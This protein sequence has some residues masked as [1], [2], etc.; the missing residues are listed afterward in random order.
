MGRSVKFNFVLSADA[1]AGDQVDDMRDQ[2]EVLGHEFTVSRGEWIEPPSFNLFCEGVSDAS[3]DRV[4]ALGQAGYQL[5]VLVT[6]KPT[7]V[8]HEGLIWNYHTGS[9]AWNDRA[10]IFVATAPNFISAWCY[11]PRAA[12]KVRRFIPNAVDIDVAWGKRFLVAKPHE[13]PRYDF[14]F[15]GGLTPRRERVLNHIAKRGHSV[16]VIPHS[17]PLAVRDSRVANSKVVI[18]PKQYHWW[19]LASPIR[20]MTALCHGRPVVAEARSREAQGRWAKV[21]SFAPE[22]AFYETAAAALGHW[23]ELHRRQTAA[24]KMLPSLVAKA[25][26][27]LPVPRSAPVHRFQEPT[28]QIIIRHHDRSSP[29]PQLLASVKGHN[30]VGWLDAVYAVPQRIGSV[31]LDKVDLLRYPMI[32]RFPNYAAAERELLCSR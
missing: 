2:I 29:A 31:H 13:K 19:D 10:E 16:D 25:V 23:Q 22:H 27:L 14:G 12:A 18:E 24:F 1:Q 26:S 20:Y 6:E 8:T 7:L 3:A 11:A 21:V 30:I 4:A 17:T 5:I 32:K 9:V 15:F 28:A